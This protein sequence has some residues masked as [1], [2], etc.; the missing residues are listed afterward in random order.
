MDDSPG[1]MDSVSV[2]DSVGLED[3]VSVIGC[4][5]VIGISGVDNVTPSGTI[6]LTMLRNRRKKY[7]VIL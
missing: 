4:V 2:V 5:V 3:S 6:G 1:I 7:Y